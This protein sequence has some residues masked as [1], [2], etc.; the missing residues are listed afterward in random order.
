MHV[1][2]VTGYEYFREG[3]SGPWTKR[4]LPSTKKKVWKA[5][6]TKA[7]K[8]LR[9]RQ[10]RREATGRDSEQHYTGKPIECRECGMVSS[11]DRYLM[12]DTGRV[13]CGDCRYE[14]RHGTPPDRAPTSGAAGNYKG[15]EF[16]SSAEQT[17]HA[18]HVRHQYCMTVRHAEVLAEVE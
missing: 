18:N 10:Q 5:A 9:S 13:L 3:P 1:N 17:I 6:Q 14:H 7:A 4:R 8:I 15:D 2:E 12:F 16:Y 11:E